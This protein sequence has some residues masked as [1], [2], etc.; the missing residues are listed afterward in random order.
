MCHVTIQKQKEIP[1]EKAAG[2][3][4][5]RLEDRQ[6]EQLRKAYGEKLKEQALIRYYF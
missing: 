5:K 3:I 4:S 1:Y 2:E 6:K